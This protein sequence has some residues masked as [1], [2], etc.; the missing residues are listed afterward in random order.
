MFFWT[1]KMLIQIK[2]TPPQPILCKSMVLNDTFF[3]KWSG[4]LILTCCN[5]IGNNSLQQ[6]EKDLEQKI[7]F[8]LWSSSYMTFHKEDGSVILF[9]F[10]FAPS[11]SLD[12]TSC[13][14]RTYLW[15]KY[16]FVNEQ[17]IEYNWDYLSNWNRICFWLPGPRRWWVE[18]LL[19]LFDI[20][21]LFLRDG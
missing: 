21:Q 18:P 1:S 20:G 14:Y 3:C 19:S 17:D 15:T 8:W 11:S 2:H 10:L 6:S 13:P 4:S 7:S 12:F 9:F 16:T 5:C